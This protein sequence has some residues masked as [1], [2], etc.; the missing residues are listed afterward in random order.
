LKQAQIIV[1]NLP[2]TPRSFSH[3]RISC[4]RA[5]I[6]VRNLGPKKKTDF[7]FVSAETNKL[8]SKKLQ[9]KSKAETLRC[10]TAVSGDCPIRQKSY[11]LK[12]RR[13]SV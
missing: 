5:T 1:L 7:C 13:R 8:V 6:K 2:K 9:S 3:A 11:G 10:A 4:R 12:R